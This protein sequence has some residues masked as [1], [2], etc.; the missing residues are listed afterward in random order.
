MQQRL[1]TEQLIKLRGRQVNI[2]LDWDPPGDAKSAELKQQ[3][4]RFGIVS[5]RKNRPSTKGYDLNDYLVE[6]SK[7]R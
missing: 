6:S 3:M 2:L 4:R 1:S 7:R 5:T